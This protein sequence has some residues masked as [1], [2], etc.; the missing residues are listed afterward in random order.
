[1]CTTRDFLLAYPLA[2][3]E[4]CFHWRGG[5]LWPPAKGDASTTPEV[6]KRRYDTAERMKQD[7]MDQTRYLLCYIGVFEI[8]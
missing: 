6:L 5:A 7:G 1:M 8:S 4:G 3:L 2:F